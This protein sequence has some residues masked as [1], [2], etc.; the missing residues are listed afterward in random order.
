MQKVVVL[1]AGLIGKAIAIDLCKN[2]QVTSVDLNRDNL[3]QLE[4]RH[5][6]HTIEADVSD[7]RSVEQLVKGC[8]LVIGAVPGFLG[9]NTLKA[10]IESGKNIVDIS[11]FDGDPFELDLL[12]KEHNVTAVIDC[13]VAPGLSNMLLAYHYQKINLT[14]FTC[15]VGGLPMERYLPF[16]YKAP[17][18]PVDVLEEYIRPVRMMEAGK[19]VTRPALSEPEYIEF[20]KIGTLEAFNTDGLRTLLQTMPLANMKEKTLRY[21]G[22]RELMESL[23]NTG[24][25]EKDALEIEG[26]SVRPLD[27]TAQLLLPKWKLMPNEEEFTVMQIVMEGQGKAKTEKIKYY[28][29]DR[30]DQA[31][32]TSSMARTTGYTCT[33]VVKLILENQFSRKGICPP[34][35]IGNESLAFEAVLEYL[36]ER[37]IKLSREIQ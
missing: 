17:F 19:V 36:E 24:F 25:L 37:G 13:G 8:D 26:V 32:Q 31:T 14:D 21:P 23:R 3:K 16:Q 9:L 30:F 20:P 10:V 7:K 35:Y 1:G 11:F 33:A 29:F 12:A 28:L 4:E 6:I 18:S 22:H 5:P 34:E 2:Y 27:V 15:Y